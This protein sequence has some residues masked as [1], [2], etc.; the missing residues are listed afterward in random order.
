MGNIFDSHAHY[1]EEKFETVL[2][3]TFKF[4]SFRI[5]SVV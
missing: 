2:P 1:D 5:K 4:D 3:S